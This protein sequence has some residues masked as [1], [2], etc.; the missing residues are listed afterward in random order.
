MA[1]KTSGLFMIGGG[2]PK[3]F[4]QGETVGSIDDQKLRYIRRVLFIARR[5]RNLLDED[6]RDTGDSHARWLTLTWVDMLDGRANHRELAERIG[7]ELPTLIRLL[8]RLEREGLVE[9]RALKDSAQSKTVVLTRKGRAASRRMTV[10]VHQT[11]KTFLDGVDA[12]QLAV[13]LALLDTLLQKYA[14]VV[15]APDLG[16]D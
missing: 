11:R 16:L 8:N 5:W 3:N 14:R 12:Q 4:V 1:A 10:V 13:S 7:V 9:R 2:V 6:L 15:Q